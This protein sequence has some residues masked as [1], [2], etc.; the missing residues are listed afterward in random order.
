MI[1]TELRLGNLVRYNDMTTVDIEVDI[2]DLILIKE[3][4]DGCTYSPI[5]L[6][7]E[8]LIKLGFESGTD[9]N[10]T[11]PVF[12]K[13]KYTFARW[14]RNKWQFWINTVDIYNSPQY[15]HQ[16]QNLYFALTGGELKMETVEQNLNK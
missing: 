2:E 9:N 13:G 10:G 5:P 1:P 4:L 8:W 7:E 11:L 6:T 12:R 14:G 3:Q 15:V 16:L